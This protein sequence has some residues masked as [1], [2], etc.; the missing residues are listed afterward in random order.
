MSSPYKQAKITLENTDDD[1][2]PESITVRGLYSE[3]H[4]LHS[5]KFTEHN[6]DGETTETHLVINENENRAMLTRR[7]FVNHKM[8]FDP[9]RKETIYYETPYGGLNM[10]TNTDSV[11]FTP[12]S[13]GFDCRIIYTV[14]LCGTP[15]RADRHDMIIKV[16][17]ID[18]P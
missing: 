6:G 3:K 11:R 12:R 13:K 7:G 1:G 9:G 10:E 2:N 18:Q 16:R 17:C 15:G 5:V 8:Q 14:F 4:G